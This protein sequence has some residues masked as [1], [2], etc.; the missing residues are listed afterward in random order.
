MPNARIN[1]GNKK[2]GTVEELD[3]WLREVLVVHIHLGIKKP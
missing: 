1:P 3:L 2:G